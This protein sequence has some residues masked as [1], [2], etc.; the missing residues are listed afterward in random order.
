MFDKD[1]WREI[2]DSLSRHKLRTLL[3]AF[4]VFWG[5][6]M[7]VLL[8]GAGK[9]L[10]N[11]VFS[12]FSDFATNGAIVY[13]TKTSLPYKGLN[14]GRWIGLNNGDLQAVKEN[15]ADIEYINANI[16]LWGQFAIMYE[17][18][19]GSFRVE[20]CLPDLL[21]IAPRTITQGRFLN[22]QD[23]T[24]KRKTAVIGRKVKEVLFRDID[25]IGK[26][27]NIKNVYFR[28]IGVFDIASMGEQNWEPTALIQIP[29]TALQQAFNQGDYI[30]GITITAKKNSSV[31]LMEKQVKTLLKGRHK[32]APEDPE[33]IGSWNM[34]ENFKRF[35]GLFGVITI[36]IWIVG[37]GTLIAGVVAVSNVMLIIVKERTREIGIRKALGAT[38]YSIITMILQESIFLTGISGY[39]GLV[40]GVGIIELTN[41]FMEKFKMQSEFFKN[42]EIDISVALTATLILVLIGGVAGLIPARNAARINPIEALRSE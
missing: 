5:I 12:Q 30:N 42:P 35:Q 32:V 17:G 15:I 25:P 11:G 18:R 36:F 8:L 6:F 21:Y 7:L 29:L 34:E 37:L 39:T 38:P 3:T 1:K 40:C 13:G 10:Q 28:I 41:Y 19:S 24:L 9:G 22:E 31:S 14:P 26:Y 20:G 23:I 16:N 27:L 33:G 2:F 4:G